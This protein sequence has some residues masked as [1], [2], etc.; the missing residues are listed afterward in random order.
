MDCLT[1]E[2]RHRAMAAN[3]SRDTQIELL[4]RKALW[5]QGLRYRKNYPVLGHRCDIVLRKYRLAIFCDGDFWH[6]RDGEELRVASNSS[7]WHNKIQRNRE[8]DFETTLALRDGGWQ[9]LRF[10]EADIRKNLAGCVQEVF[11]TIALLQELQEQRRR[12]RARKK[13]QALAA[14]GQPPKAADKTKPR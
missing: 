11:A 8:R 4:L 1:P 5:H 14:G 10:W 3:K 12:Q 9:V 13:E 2:Q 7:Y 6:G